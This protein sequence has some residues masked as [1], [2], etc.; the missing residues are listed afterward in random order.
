MR[1][2]LC[3]ETR[4]SLLVAWGDCL[5]TLAADTRQVACTMAWALDGIVAA[6]VVPMDR[7]H[8]AVLGHVLSEELDVTTNQRIIANAY[9]MELQILDRTNGSIVYS[10]LLQLQE[11]ELASPEERTHLPD[12]PSVPSTIH[13][14]FRLLSSFAVPRMDDSLELKEER[15]GDGVLEILPGDEFVDS[16]LKWDLSM[17]SFQESFQ[18]D[19][20]NASNRPNHEEDTESV[21]SDDY[22]FMGKTTNTS[23]TSYQKFVPPPVLVIVSDNDTVL[24]RIRDLDD[25]IQFALDNR[26]PALALRWALASRVHCFQRYS[27]NDLVNHC[28][29]SLLRL[30]S[31]ST[32]ANVGTPLPARHLSLRRMTLAAQAL[33]FLLG[34]NVDLWKLWLSEF[35]MIPGALFLVCKYIP[36]RG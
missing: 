1:P 8:V 2:H 35:E 4:R 14:N 33:P 16:H 36:V 3:W 32:S 25:A 7:R 18:M 28:L 34:G 17:V 29:R 5:M 10:D 13:S 30:Q 6:D 26:K 21:D 12:Q 11:T 19:N 9:E 22:C 24:A 23:E 20:D 15:G 31:S 27:L